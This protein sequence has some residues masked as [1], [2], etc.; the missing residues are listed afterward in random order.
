MKTLSEILTDA[1]A[2]LD[3]EATEPTGDELT[4]RQNYANQAVDDASDRVQ[5]NEFKSEYMVC[6]SSNVTVPLPSNFRELQEDPR[7]LIGSIWETWP[8]I[9]VEERYER[10]TS[11]RYSYILG[12]PAGGYYLI[13][14]DPEANC[15]LSII[16]QRY[17]S[18]MA[19]LTDQCE[20]SEPTY[21][22]R[23][24]ESYVLY[25]RGDDKFQIAETRAEKQLMNMAGRRM[26]G[27]GGQSKDTPMKFA[28]PLG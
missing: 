13:L 23:K 10:S 6:I 18:G 16:Y 14:N 21:V 20:L 25:G 11:A 1:N 8:E 7:L 4:L 2:V 15:T 12:N 26:K 9:E 19:T 27:T 28:S 24:L 17:P 22:T 3:L 5:L